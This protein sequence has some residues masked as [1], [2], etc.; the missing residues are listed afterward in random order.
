MLQFPT[1]L[2]AGKRLKQSRLIQKNATEEASFLK[3]ALSLHPKQG[4]MP[5]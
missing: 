4:K 1:T 3:K 2:F 5:E